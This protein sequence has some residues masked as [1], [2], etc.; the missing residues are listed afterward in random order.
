MQTFISTLLAAAMLILGLAASAQSADPRFCSRS[1]THDRCWPACNNDPRRLAQTL[2]RVP[3]LALNP[4]AG[5]LPRRS[6]LVVVNDNPA[7]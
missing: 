7:S 6:A 5:H 1:P 2:K 4:F 3:A